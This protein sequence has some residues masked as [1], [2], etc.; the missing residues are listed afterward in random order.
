MNNQQQFARVAVKE[1]AGTVIIPSGEAYSG[2]HGDAKG[3][4]CIM[5]TAISSRSDTTIQKAHSTG[6]TD[7]MYLGAGNIT[8]DP[9][10]QVPSAHG[11]S[12]NTNYITV[13]Y[14]HKSFNTI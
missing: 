4:N 1:T 5:I 11:I 12:N 10:V 13:A 14:Y 9:P 8:F 7:F 2:V 6:N 3:K